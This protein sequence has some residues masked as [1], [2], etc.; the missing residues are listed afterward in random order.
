MSKV[1]KFLPLQETLLAIKNQALVL[2]LQSEIS[3]EERE[4]MMFEY[5]QHEAEQEE[6]G[7]D[8]E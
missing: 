3:D 7:Y 4:I 5:M 2:S 8:F 6:K 1:N